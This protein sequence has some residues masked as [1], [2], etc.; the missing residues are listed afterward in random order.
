MEQAAAMQK[1]W[2][3]TV[4]GMVDAW[5][6]NV[7]QSGSPE[8]LK[9]L[10]GGLLQAMSKSWEEFMR[11][12]QFMEM[13]SGSMKAALSMRK[14]VKDGLNKTHAGLQTPSSEDIE[15]LMLAIRHIERR[16]LDRID[17]TDRQLKQV[18]DGLES[19]RKARGGEARN[20]HLESTIL[21]RLDAI[22]EQL[23][24]RDPR[25]KPS[26]RPKAGDKRGKLAPRK[27][28]TS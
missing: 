23:D 10:R 15:S 19:E 3:D 16:I 1:L 11:T 22:S 28:K 20:G 18:Q 27:R 8:D 4:S 12:P 2:S 21:K 9:K 6:N 24:Q 26:N 7:P 17:D 25:V 5:S 13:M 14:T